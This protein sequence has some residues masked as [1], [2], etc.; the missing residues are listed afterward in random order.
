MPNPISRLYSAA[1]V[2]EA[3]LD[4]QDSMRL[5]ELAHAEA[6]VS[7]LEREIN[8]D[9]R[10]P[11]TRELMRDQARWQTVVVAASKGHRSWLWSKGIGR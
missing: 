11:A 5:A 7:R 8:S 2:L 6:E 9:L 4:E 3:T 10:H 1:E